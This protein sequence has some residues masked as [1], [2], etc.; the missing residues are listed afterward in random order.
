MRLAVRVKPGHSRT[1]VGGQ[2]GGELVVHVRERAVEGAAT[3]AAL[4][5]VAEALGLRPYDVTLVSG[6]T[7][8]SKVLEIPDGLEE[9]VAALME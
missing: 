9:R 1:A 3:K 8:R 5:A 2:H 7:S 4:K 6:V